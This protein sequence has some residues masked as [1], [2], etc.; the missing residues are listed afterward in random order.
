M[1]PIKH[2]PPF[3][4]YSVL[5]VGVGSHLASRLGELL[6]AIC[7]VE[8]VADFV[9]A[10]VVIK[11][12]PIALV[13]IEL[14]AGEA[15]ESYARVFI[16]AGYALPLLAIDP[17]DRIF[18][19]P[20]A[21]PQA[22]H[23]RARYSWEDLPELIIHLLQ[24]SSFRL[25]TSLL[26]DTLETVANNVRE[27]VI[28]VDHL[29]V[30]HS[31]NPAALN[32]CHFAGPALGHSLLNQ[33]GGCVPDIAALLKRVI[34]SR[35]AELNLFLACA[36]PAEERTEIRVSATP[37]LDHL[38]HCFG[39]VVVILDR[40]SMT[41]LPEVLRKRRTFHRLIGMSEKMQEVYDL[42][43]SLANMDTTTLITGESGVGKE[44]VA[45]A[46][47]FKGRRGH[48]PLV[49]VNCAALQDN[50]LE[51]ELFGHVKGAFTGAVRDRPGRFEAAAG[52]TIF[53]D[54]IGDISLSMQTRL[55]RILQEKELERV[56]DSRTI[57]VDVRVVA[58][59]NKDLAEQIRLGRF[60]EDLYFRLN[61]VEINVPP[62]RKRLDDIPVLV[63]H[64]IQK[65]NRKYEK[66][67]VGVQ[68]SVMEMLL[69]YPWPGNIR[70]LENAIEHA[71]VVCRLNTIRIKHLP[72]NLVVQRLCAD[73]LSGK[74]EEEEESPPLAS[75]IDA[76]R[77]PPSPLVTVPVPGV[78]LPSTPVAPV[79][80]P[81]TPVAPVPAAP[82]PPQSEKEAL[83]RAL[84]EAQWKKKKAAKLLG[85]SRS[86]FYRKLEKY[87]IGGDEN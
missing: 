85:V 36:G 27:G 16:Q 17:A 4:T 2:H 44:L 87:G 62:L 64:F 83:L 55:L 12:I 29:M 45:E 31:V 60:R 41:P 58:A 51:S 79:S 48:G 82:V 52:G 59:T 9:A 80:L 5:L 33:K 37:L 76:V 47:H 49:K 25:D 42:I 73:P 53:L 78:P 26:R 71:F 86:T 14:P 57:R 50:L 21:I 81:S 22:I 68:D 23:F 20:P 63:N 3:H 10:G 34:V 8:R 69:Q 1:I 70:E 6:H 28:V 40:A 13:V 61:V 39:A 43:E 75:R 11:R 32:A 30:V 7:P 67:I 15:L 65:F 77:L 84:A 66:S 24:M 35:K 74:S 54:E 56:G 38:G 19:I 18:L 46:L 72:K